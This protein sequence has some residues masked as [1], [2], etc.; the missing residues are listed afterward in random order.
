M[1][2]RIVRCLGVA[3]AAVLALST[4]QACANF[5]ELTG[6]KAIPNPVATVD[7][8]VPISVLS[9]GATVALQAMAR[10]AGGQPVSD[11]PVVWSSSDTTIAR[12]S[13]AG[14]VTAV[15]VGRVRI[16]ASVDGRSAVATLSVT[17]RSVAS[18]VVRPGNPSI[19][20]G[21]QL[22]L[23]STMLGESG[24]TLAGR[25]VLWTSS[26]PVV[27]SIDNVGLLTGL[28]VGVTTVT[29]TS[30]NRTAAVGVTVSAVPVNAVQITP[31]V[32][33]VVV[34]Q[35]TQLTAFARDSVGGTLADRPLVWLSSDPAIATVTSSGTV[36][37]ASA[38][39]VTI[40][41]SAEGKTGTS[42]IVVKPRPVSAIIVSPSQAALTVGQTVTLSVLITDD[43]GTLLTGRPLQFVSSNAAVATVAASGTVTARAS[44]SAII[45]VTSEGRTGTVNVTVSSSPVATVR[46]DPSTGSVLIGGTV[47]LSAVALDGAGNT[48][49]QRPIT[50]R[51]GAP[52]VAT[53][54][55]NGTVTGVGVGTALVFAT[56]EGKLA[57]ATISVRAVAVTAVIV[58]PTTSNIFV[59]DTIGLNAEVREAA[60][61]VLNGRV[62]TWASSDERIAVVSS[63]GRARALAP[64]TVL[65]TATVDGVVGS[66]SISTTA[67]PVLTITVEPSS[68]GL[69]P[70]ASATLAAT[71]RGR[72]GVALTGRGFA[73]AS[74]DPSIATVSLSGVVTAIR[75]GNT[76][77]T[78]TSEGKSV[79]VNVQVSPAPVATV[80]V[81][82]VAPARYVGQ[83]TQATS[84]SKDAQGN[85]LAGRTVAWSTSNA[86]VATITPSGV[87]SAVSPGIATIT[88]TVEG[89]TASASVTV[90]LVP[91]STVGVVIANSARYVGQTTQVTASTLDSVGGVLAG[92]D[93]AWS[94]SNASVATVSASGV[95]SALAVGS[96][97]I[98]A[99]SE[100][101]SGSALVTVTLTPVAT[102]TVTAANTSRY[103]GQTT[104]ATATLSDAQ[105]NVLT[106]RSI[107]WSSSD[108]GVAT[109]SGTGLVTAIAPGTVNISATSEGIASS[110]SITVTPIPVATVNVSLARNQFGT[111]QTTQAT[112]VTLDPSG[113]V[114]TGRA[115]SWSSSNPLVAVV[116]TSGLVTGG[117]PGTANIIAT[118]EGKS[119]TAVVTIVLV[120]VGNV[121]VAVQPTAIAVGKTG[122][123]TATILDT[124]GSPT[125]GR[126]VTWTSSAPAV[127]TISATGVITGISVGS[128]TITATSAGVS[129]S[130]QVS[131]TPAAVASVSIVLGTS[132]VVQNQ[133][134]PSAVTLRD[135]NNNVLTGRIV[136]YASSAPAVAT[137]SASG[138]V[139]AVAP[140]TAVISATSEGQ[141]GNANLTVTAAPVATVTVALA[142]S[143]ITVGKTTQATDT[144]RDASNNVLVGRAVV[145][146]SS[147][148]NVATVSNAGLVTAVAAGTANIIATSETQTG[149]ASLTV[150]LTPVASVSTT[151]AASSLAQG[152]STQAS[153][154]VKDA[155]GN[156][157]TG[158]VVTWLSSNPN[159]ATVSSTGVVTALQPGTSDIRATS[160]GVF[161]VASVTVTSVP[162][163]SVTVSFN[164][165]SLTVGATTLATA[166]I[167]DAVGNVLN[168]RTVT[169]SSGNTAVATV[170]PNTGVV[171]A[172]S[173]GSAM[174]T[175][176]SEGI[177]SS[178]S[179][180]VTP[181][182]VATVNVSLARNQFGTLQ[183]TQATAVTL[184]PSGNVLTGRAISWSSSNPLVAVVSTSGLVTGGIPGTANIIAT[185]EG[186]SGTAVVTIVLV[187]V[188]NVTV[189]VQPPAIVVGKT[190][191][192]TATILDTNGAP[193][194]GRAV[195]WTSSAPAV[196]TISASGVITAISVGTTSIT[197]TSDGVSGATQV[198]ITPAAVASVSI[199]LGTS[200]IVQNQTTPSAV[201]L[202]DA[203][204]N[205]LTGR[206]VTYASS[207]PAVATVSASGVVSALAPGTAV[208][209]ATSEGQTGNANLTVTAAPVATVTVA[210]A[211]S[212]ITV[213]KTTQATDTL[214]DASNNVL[215]GRAVAWTSSNTNVATV[216]N[217][218]LVTAVAAGTA[219]IIA[220]SEAKTGLASLT[221]SVTPVASVSTTLA[222]SSLAQG[223]TTQATARVKD[224]DGNVLTGR[225][226]TWVSSNPSIATVSSTGVV[227]ALQAGTSDIRATSEGVFGVATVTVTTVPVA[228]VTVSLNTASLPVGATTQA[229]AILRDAVGNVL[230]GRTVTWSSGNTA[231]ATVNPNTGVVTAVSAGSATITAAS[232]TKSGN[233]TVSVTA[234]PVATV[235][236]TLTPTSVGVGQTSQAS[237]V[238]LDANNNPL[239]GRIVTWSS[240]NT[241]VASVN[242]SSGVITAI[243]VG[244][245]VITGTSETKTGS[246]TLTVIVA[247][248][249]SVN[250]MLADSSVTTG[251]TVQGSTI[252]RD[253]NHN[254]LTARRVVW[255]TSNSAIATVNGTTGLVSA[256][257]VGTV[258]IIAT[259]EGVSDAVALTIIPAVATITVSLN[260]DSVIAGASSQATAVTL[261]AANSPLVGRNVAWSSSNTAVATVNAMTGAVTT[262]TAGTTTIVATSEGKS[263]SAQLTVLAPVATVTVSLVAST[264]TVNKTTQASAVL[265]D[266]NNNVLTGR[267]VVWSTSNAAVAT[268]S[269]TGLVTAKKKGSAQ[270][271]ATSEAIT[272]FATVKV[273]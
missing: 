10:D 67:E 142:A 62:I 132:T 92:R 238:T 215:A 260:P 23:F 59:G 178:I 69:L 74:A 154:V 121:T 117:M 124:D 189:T 6:P 103:V 21:G 34:G 186:K 49:A 17:A 273:P 249:D 157:L 208:I 198:S 99:T 230:N 109:V 257:A 118:S 61:S 5:N 144:L 2:S 137:V 247:P 47:N 270:I 82:I 95:V 253:A 182:P 252:L 181:I 266:S 4:M 40:S 269:P 240:G 15:G 85:V 8:P 51:S 71:A 151:L 145:W 149:S 184:D 244:T 155:D 245:V 199:V 55:A 185:S 205:V 158:R 246:A 165:A 32:D 188:R 29:A 26:D 243:A 135:A 9:V 1:R 16:A 93:I 156:V 141:T 105:G 78:V 200:S 14:V 196:A 72:N 236:A 250:A 133:T 148:T 197:A 128:S 12:V 193:T 234:I 147:N 63:T 251:S 97:N 38:G 214:R 241:S 54:A 86:N 33:S 53:V 263:G 166:V 22:Q 30:E 119:G 203:N 75:T 175:A 161:G 70:T 183:T 163:A 256:V 3:L 217:A 219:N 110:I 210:L 152:Q 77:I 57:S 169:W 216:D 68:L 7:V 164:A 101:K 194:T 172:V 176:T 88:A 207:A 131:I 209:S 134:T 48:L 139:S 83:T 87:I 153:A 111:L 126:A 79:A 44:G 20:V 31:A 173:A 192:A 213:G 122:Q 224:A 123:A 45:T 127:A 56:I 259:S 89:K 231:V 41:A 35:T 107:V 129:G 261:D 267:D 204:N 171:T 222:A 28:S 202:R 212:M 195:T 221:V 116:S 25:N 264:V 19:L 76:T 91:V 94:S 36:L 96:A 27:A 225:V 237:A 150:S 43:N 191:Q 190:G 167:R 168:G 170:N 37:G 104:Q 65:I 102:V 146:T 226:V 177:A 98:I 60:G 138:V 120:P 228:S 248:V 265:K 232:E 254:V 114:L 130:T 11:R 13:A 140:G 268:V 258:N 180:T 58:T 24:D 66:A 115:I 100:G 235:T 46:I 242:S 179:I 136:T 162:V 174:I 42:R 255:A 106:G 52:S 271:R 125:T 223:Q 90:A 206:I 239:T 73:Y 201:T 160:E 218:G 108:A 272:D 211:A 18:V 39:S 233:A 187:P 143:T 84:T 64:G 159:I 229:T 227:T 80:A 220:T 81:S 262:L 112:A 113:N 50:W